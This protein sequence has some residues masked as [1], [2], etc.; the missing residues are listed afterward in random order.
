MVESTP[1]AAGHDAGW[2]HQLYDP[3]RRAGQK[4]ADYFSPQAEAAATGAAY[5]INVELPGVAKEDI[6]VE[7]RGDT[8]T[9]Q[10]EKRF[11]REGQGRTYFFSE[12][13]YG[14]FQRSFRL[15]PD[16]DQ[17]AITATHT[18]GVLMLRIGKRDAATGASRRIEVGGG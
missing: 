8:V 10:G 15:P 5:E 13:A 9:V 4:I 12:R 2:L 17:S 11:S 14:A 6:H 3:L 16:A 18:D 1:S 7:V